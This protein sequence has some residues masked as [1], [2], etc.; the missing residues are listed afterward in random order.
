MAAAKTRLIPLYVDRVIYDRIEAD[1]LATERRVPQ[2]ATYLLK[3]AL[4]LLPTDER[5]PA[6]V[7]AGK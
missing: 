7:T 5:E 2:M 6:A 3:Q 1:A 4:G